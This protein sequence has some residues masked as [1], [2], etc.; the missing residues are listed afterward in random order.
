[1][2]DYN[3][4]PHCKEDIYEVTAYYGLIDV[5]QILQMQFKFAW[6]HNKLQKTLF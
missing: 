6:C 2:F 5:V 1:M 3:Y 4:F